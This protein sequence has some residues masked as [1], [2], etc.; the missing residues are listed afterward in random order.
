MRRRKKN[1][2]PGK[3][4]DRNL[5]LVGG[6][7]AHLH[8]LPRAEAFRERGMGL[9]LVDPGD[10]WY[11]GMATGLLSGGYSPAEDRVDLDALC[12]RWGVTYIRERAVGLEPEGRIL[13]TDTARR[14]PYELL[15]LNVGSAVDAGT[16]DDPDNLA[17]P[18]KPISR[19]PAL[20]D[21][22]K[23]VAF[24]RGGC[25]VV[26]IGG[27]PTGCEVAA[28]IEVLLRGFEGDSQVALLFPG[29][30]L[31]SGG[32]PGA[33][34]LLEREFHRR[35]MAIHP[36]CRVNSLTSDLRGCMLDTGEGPQGP[37]EVVVRAT[38]LKAAPV[39]SSLGFA[40]NGLK[41][42]A[43]LRSVRY[44]SIFG[45]GDC[46]AFGPQPLPKVGVFAV[47]QAPV[48][49]QNLL[50]TL[51]GRELKAYRPQPQSLTILNLGDGT[52]LALRGK[53]FFRG[54][55]AF[56]LKHFL[57]RRFLKQFRF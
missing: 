46:I 42:D 8:I 13:I 33:G 11:S 34:D 44:P 30:R 36:G 55:L 25:R 21:H 31:L 37:F 49:R 52:G 24:A 56:M 9:V 7:H 27:G 10:F 28:N 40:A 57:D 43:T 18:V 41:V 3:T 1:N 16:L 4:P 38:G 26:V 29:D 19:L 32:P 22:L 6:G 15:S 17:W 54:R 53:F 48:L 14:L 5:V 2:Q 39:L 20:R 23:E 35:G 47:R 50:A 12:R 51:A 45:A